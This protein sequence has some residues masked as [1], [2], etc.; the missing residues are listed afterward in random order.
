MI[1]L[2]LLALSIGIYLM[3]NA[4]SLIMIY[5]ILNAFNL[6]NNDAHNT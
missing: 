1:C 4:F 3:L 2:M 6:I 5:L